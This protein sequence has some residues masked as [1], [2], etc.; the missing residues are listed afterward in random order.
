MQRLLKSGE[1]SK[2]IDNKRVVK[3]Q[4][5]V[6]ADVWIVIGSVVVKIFKEEYPKS[7]IECEVSILDRL[8]NMQV[9]KCIDRLRLDNKEVLIYEYIDG[10]ISLNPNISQ[11]REIAKFMRLMHSNLE[12]IKLDICKDIY[13]NLDSFKDEAIKYDTLFKQDIEKIDFT[14]LNDTII[15]KDL[16]PDN[17]L[18]NGDRLSSVID[19]S[20]AC[21]GDRYFD[22]ATTLFSWCR[23]DKSKI[24]AFLDAYGIELDKMR[25]KE[26]L[27]FAL[28]YYMFNRFKGGRNWQ[29][30]YSLRVELMS[31][32]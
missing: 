32:M 23:S 6:S 22:V 3:A 11:I 18:F 25:L 24:E 28:L 21:V 29:E 17:A 1:I 16:F 14:P 7:R 15:H 31:L 12:G 4:Y 30:L 8:K 9:A 5:G 19:F 2:Y 27:N 26:A 10:S 13:F 20:D